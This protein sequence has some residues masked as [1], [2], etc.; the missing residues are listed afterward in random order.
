MSDTR[1]AE[2]IVRFYRDMQRIRTFEMRVIDVFRAA[3]FA[4]FLHSAVGQEGVAVGAC[5]ALRKSDVITATHRSHGHLI[6][7]GV[8]MDGLLAEIYGKANGLCQG[9]AGHVHV[10]D[11]NNGVIGGNGVLGQNQPIAVGAALA[12]AM[13][14]RDD[15]VVSFFGDG[16][17]NEGA[18]HEAMNLAAVWQLPVIFLCERNE[19]AELT[20]YSSHFRIASIADRAKAYG[21]AGYSIDG[22]D[23]E[24]VADT[25]GKVVTE[26]R[27]GQG[28]ALVEARVVRWRGHYEGDP[29]AYR[30]NQ[31]LSAD[32]LEVLALRYPSV[33][34]PELRQHIEGEAEAETEAAV[35]FARAGAYPDPT[36]LFGR[37]SVVARGAA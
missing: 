17:A 5:A 30:Q 16:T 32:P 33:L 7:K 11:L 29:Q 34:T 31:D 36:I 18:V 2:E 23:V 8:A 27:A 21:F 3:E 1:S 26:A 22:S 15:V 37:N 9:V 10:A 25:V 28:P 6:A 14:R 24:A 4:G 19:F 35:A 13:E 20:P 12:I